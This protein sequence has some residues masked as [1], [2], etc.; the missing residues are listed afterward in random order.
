MLIYRETDMSLDVHL[1]QEFIDVHTCTFEDP[2]HNWLYFSI[3]GPPKTNHFRLLW[4]AFLCSHDH[5]GLGD[6]AD[7]SNSVKEALKS[8]Y[9][10]CFHKTLVG[11]L[12]SQCHRTASKASTEVSPK[13]RHLGN[14]KK[15]RKQKGLQEFGSSKAVL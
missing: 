12:H 3:N 7:C 6:V 2:Y 1:M 5:I 13:G 4:R 10:A 15:G 9:H 14:S 11:L 8:L